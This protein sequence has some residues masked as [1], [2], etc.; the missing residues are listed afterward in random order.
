MVS[1]GFKDGSYIAISMEAGRNQGEK[2]N[3]L[4]GILRQFVLVYIIADESDVIKLRTNYRKNP[5]R[6][7]PLKLDQK[8]IRLIFVDILKRA[9][10][11]TKQP[12]FYNTLTNNCVTNLMHHIRKFSAKNI[13]KFNLSYLLP[14]YSDQVFYKAGLL[15]TELSINQVRKQFMIT[16]KAQSCVADE[17]FSA[18]IRAR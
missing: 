7:L 16:K 11:I 3:P 14:G 2:F 15:D 13:S 17:D 1:F 9:Q 18:C 8:T 12:E 5:V 10:K 6:L 4:K